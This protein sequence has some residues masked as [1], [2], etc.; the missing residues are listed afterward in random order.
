MQPNSLRTLP[1]KL[2]ASDEDSS[3]E[4]GFFEHLIESACVPT[5][6]M[7]AGLDERP[8]GPVNLIWNSL[9]DNDLERKSDK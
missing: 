5:N 7:L 9:N 3:S 8:S 6:K 4:I 2:S 1:I